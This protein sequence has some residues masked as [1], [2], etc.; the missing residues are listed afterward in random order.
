MQNL[1]TLLPDLINHI[2][3]LYVRAWTFTDDKIPTLAYSESVIRFSKLLSIICRSHGSLD[4]QGLQ[5]IV[6]NTKTPK[7][8]GSGD[9]AGTFP[10]KAEIAMVL[11][12]AFPGPGS[13]ED[14]PVADRTVIL[15]GISSV[16]SDLGY[17]RKKALVLKELASALLPALVQARKEGAAE[18]GVHPAASL[19]AL[20]AAV[21]HQTSKPVDG[22]IADSEHGMRDFLA[23]ICKEYGIMLPTPTRLEDLEND[24]CESNNQ[25]SSNTITALQ[26]YDSDEIIIA[27]AVEQA[28]ISLLGAQQLKLDVLRA[29]INICEALP[30]LGGV[31]RFSADTLRTAGSGVAP[32][33][34]SDNGSPALPLE[35]QVRLANNISRTLSA[36]QQLG[37]GLLEG[38][39]W[40]EFIVRGID[41]G[42]INPTKR[43]IPH[44]KAELAIVHTTKTQAVKTPFI[45]NPFGHKTASTSLE[46]IFVAGEDIMFRVTLQNLYDFDLEVEALKLESKGVFFESL[47][48]STTIGPYR[49]QT[50]GLKGIP[51]TAGS[52]I[53]TGCVAKIKGCRERRFPLFA[54][55]WSLKLDARTTPQKLLE[56]NVRRGH[57]STELQENAVDIKS[58]GPRPSS[59]HSNIIDSQPNV[60]LKSISLPQSA[61]ML[62]E[63]ET[64]IF[65]VTL[66][67]LSPSVTAD[68]VLISFKDSTASQLQ[69]ALA[70]KALTPAELYELEFSAAHSKSFKLLQTDLDREPTIAPGGTLTFSVEMFGRPGLSHGT[71]QI[72]FAHLG[73]SRSEVPSQFYTRQLQ[74]PLAVTVNASVDLIRNDLI[75]FTSNFAWQNQR[76]QS[77]PPSTSSSSSSTPEH[78]GWPSSSRRK[79]KDDNQFA[80][81]LSRLGL[82]SQDQQHVLL[83]LDLRNSWPN[84]LHTSIQVR[85]TSSYSNDQPPIPDVWK[86]A[87]TV[88]ETQ[89]PGHTSRL[90]LIIPRLYVSNPH[91]PIPSLNESTKRQFVVSASR[92]A[93]AEVELAAREA[94]WYREELLKHICASWREDSTG[95]SGSINIRSLRLSTRMISALKLEDLAIRFSVHP[96]WSTSAPATSGDIKQTSLNCFAI[97]TSTFV[98]LQVHLRNRSSLPIH[99]LLRLQPLL[100]YQPHNIALDLS[101]KLIWNGLLQR[102]LPVM[103]AKETRDVDIG[104]CAL[105]EGHFEIGAV[106]EEVKVLEASAGNDGSEE[107]DVEDAVLKGWREG[108]RDRRVWYSDEPCVLIAKE[109]PAE[110]G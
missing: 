6:R 89:Q 41:F 105:S 10:S 57:T 22:H 62:L 23:L 17:H 1:S 64:K 9:K 110:D 55:P 59:L 91:A 80:S 109:L 102:V 92:E 52:L 51:S 15:A 82:H 25:I 24:V 106:V 40:D 73:V 87:Y 107:R 4:E 50:M 71:I 16:L 108:K 32:G 21:G 35:D 72:D 58:Y 100:R 53:I 30:D 83:L 19:I 63:G 45:H 31:L 27:R 68:L 29:C 49:T 7:G 104:I 12:R 84:L 20:S 88:H 103:G 37:A 14:L 39:Y 85:Q 81:L 54:E 96:S 26:N 60:V 74:I 76:R 94:F 66:Q 95:R 33:P 34:E 13:E 42:E 67:N 3:N 86:R 28:S 38:E 101:K 56:S 8:Q 47:P 48:I 61:A 36:S 77:Q 93:S 99:P 44:A 2:L 78:H 43:P 65:T 11:F 5:R 90:V 75:P 46:P 79:S 97:P 18:M 70:N 98:T 69:S